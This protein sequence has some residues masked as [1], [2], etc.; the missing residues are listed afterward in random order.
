MGCGGD[1]SDS[2]ISGDKPGLSGSGVD[3]TQDAAS[4]RTWPT[5]R[6]DDLVS[7]DPILYNDRNAGATIKDQENARRKA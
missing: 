1:D 2:G 5:Y 7:T 4:G 3:S 6:T